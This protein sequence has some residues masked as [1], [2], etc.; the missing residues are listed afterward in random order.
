MLTKS[1][2]LHRRSFK[3]HKDVVNCFVVVKKKRD[4][5]RERLITAS[6]DGLIK[7][8]DLETGSFITDFRAVE[9]KGKEGT[10]M[11][12]HE[13]GVCCL[14]VSQGFLYS[15][16]FDT[17]IAKWDIKEKT[18]VATY[19]GHSEAVYR[20]AV[21]ENW[22][23]SAS[24]DKTVRVWRE[25]DS[26]CVAV[27]KGHTG[28]VLSLAVQ[29]DILFTGAD[30]CT[31]RQWDWLSGSQLRE[32]MGHTD[33]VT[34]LKVQGDS[35]YSSSFDSTIRVWDTQTGQCVRVC[36]ANAGM[37]GITLTA[38]KIFGAGNDAHL[39][40]WDQNS[41]QTEP[42]TSDQ[43]ARAGLTMVMVEGHVVIAS[44]GDRTCRVWEK[45]STATV[46][47]NGQEEHKSL[48]TTSKKE[49]FSFPPGATSF[50]GDL[51]EDMEVGHRPAPHESS[52]T[53]ASQSLVNV[54]NGLHDDKVHGVVVSEGLVFSA[55]SDR[56]IGCT[57]LNPS[58]DAKQMRWSEHKDRVLAVTVA[59]EGEV[60]FSASADCS[61]K[62]WDVAT[63][64]CLETLSGHSDWVSCLL[65]S[66]GSLFSGSWDSSIRKW[67]V[68][69]CR[70]IAE[71][72]AHNDPIYCLAA[73][74]GVVFSGSRDCTIRAWRTDTGECIFVYEGHTAVVASLVVADPYIY[75][76][77]WDKTIRRWDIATGRCTLF[78]PQLSQPVLCLAEHR[79]L[80]F[81]GT[82]DGVI[83]S[84]LTDTGEEL[85]P[86][87]SYHETAV[88]SLF[89]YD[90]HLFSCSNDSTVAQW[91]IEHSDLDRGARQVDVS[92]ASKSLI[93]RII[94][95]SS[96]VN[97]T[98]ASSLTLRLKGESQFLTQTEIDD[99]VPSMV[100][101][102]L[103]KQGSLF[104]RWSKRYYTL[105]KGI[106]LYHAD[107]HTQK[108]LDHLVMSDVISV[109]EGDKDVK[110][111]FS[112]TLVTINRVHHLAAPDEEEL[113][114]WISAFTT[115]IENNNL[116]KKLAQ[117]RAARSY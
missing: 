24:R 111:P 94:G 102:W 45:V 11:K 108:P 103:W 63:G 84:Y 38:G 116:Q 104:R 101:G 80:L 87:F 58:S 71:L 86:A 83:R 39:Y 9:V 46:Q 19:K 55:S 88:N 100:K 59:G 23:I 3:G 6:S 72:N 96:L 52:E 91:K 35:L 40:V 107:E 32:Y 8:W 49:R 79:Q 99:P 74:V 29:E 85:E 69:T 56:T 75:S 114:K 1:G 31:I 41:A 20:L 112:F 43:F 22:L 73:G 65:V 10:E 78:C 42:L 53:P 61:I 16:S 27:L 64:R 97:R 62:K 30:D 113:Q 2:Y 21:R 51:M 25:K 18:L 28:P 12:S 68:A 70:F 115:Y 34:D 33:C 89:V 106:L 13:Q 14:T 95:S 7:E 90:D 92:V 5:E 37:R 67:D 109:A 66:E 93:D 48:T 50:L 44:S 76:A 36:K 77:S 98:T 47:A 117:K 15:G 26:K 110:K 4:D 60:V 57:P 54:Y 81:A 105:T 82:G 17:T